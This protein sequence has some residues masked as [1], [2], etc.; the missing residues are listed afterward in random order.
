MTNHNLHS[1]G[2]RYAWGYDSGAPTMVYKFGDEWLAYCRRCA[3]RFGAS[4]QL[5]RGTWQT[6]VEVAICHVGLNDDHRLRVI[7]SMT[8]TT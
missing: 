4:N 5:Y 3:D 2:S 1:H 8:M 6:A 7:D